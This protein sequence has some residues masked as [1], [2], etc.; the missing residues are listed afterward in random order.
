MRGNTSQAKKNG[1]FMECGGHNLRSFSGEGLP[2]LFFHI[3]ALPKAVARLQS[4]PPKPMTT[5]LYG[6]DQA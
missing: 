4:L 6:H 1:R 3:H 2:P 5:A